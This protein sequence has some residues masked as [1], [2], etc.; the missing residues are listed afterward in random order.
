MNAR[1]AS[2]VLIEARKLRGRLLLW[3]SLAVLALLVGVLH[4]MLIVTLQHPS[5]QVPAEAV[6]AI[7]SMLRWPA[8]LENALTF[9]DGGGLGGLI[10]VVLAGAFVAQEITWHTA[11]LWLSRAVGRGALLL[12]KFVVLAAAGWLV[13]LAALWAGG[14]VTGAYGLLAYHHLPWGQVDW[15]RL[16]L[17]TLAVA[18]SLFPYVALAMLVAVVSRSTVVTLGVS[19]GFNLLIENLLIQVL[20]MVSAGGATISSYLPAMLGRAITSSFTTAQA[21]VEVG[22]ANLPGLH[23]LSPTAAALLIAVYT[24]LLLAA[25]AFAFYKQDVTV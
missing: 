10:M 2:L 4:F 13:V 21:H 24:G 19:V 17:H 3:G 20:Q 7:K 8:A 1:F 5:P 25:A 15:P 9:A 14:T 6:A 11:P 18:Y 16:L 22:H 23:L 12:A